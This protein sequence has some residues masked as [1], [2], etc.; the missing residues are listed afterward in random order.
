[1]NHF[2]TA[3]WAFGIAWCAGGV[4]VL[5]LATFVSSLISKRNSVIDVAWGFGF[6]I[7]AGVSFGWSAGHG[8]ELSR[9]LL[10]L[11]PVLWG[12]RLGTYIGLRQRGAGEDPRYTQLLD[13]AAATAPGTSRTILAI[14]KIYVP[15]AL[16]ILVIS[17]PVQVGMYSSAAPGILTWIGI[18]VWAVGILF[19]SVGDFQLASFKADPEHRGKIMDRGLWKFTRH[20][21]YFGD[22]CVWWGIFLVVAGHWPGWLTVLAPLVM[23]GLLVRGT[24]KATL[25]HHMGDRPGFADYVR[26]TSGFFPA[27][28]SLTRAI[29]RLVAAHRS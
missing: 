23:N 14:R 8:N 9:V 10:L 27:P 15:Q 19:E 4:G 5:L 7:V 6:A 11:L 29:N 3:R 12:A 1:M 21:N 26:S 17:M 13:R 2:E 16:S 25:E 28:P 18:A 22:A 20:P 24:G